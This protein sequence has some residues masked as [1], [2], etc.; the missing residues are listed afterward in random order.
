MAG[1]EFLRRYWW[2]VWLSAEVTNKPVPVRLLNP[3]VDKD[4]ET[5]CHKCLEKD[6]ALRY[7]TA[8]ALARDLQNFLDG[9]SIN[10]RSSNVL[11]RLTR[12][13]ARGLSPVASGMNLAT[14]AKP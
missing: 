12:M 6:P 4:L 13:L 5:I 2:P 1:G 7:A 11:D 9:N 14:V 3:N 8:E 10:A